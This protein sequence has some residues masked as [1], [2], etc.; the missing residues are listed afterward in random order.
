MFLPYGKQNLPFMKKTIIGALVGGIIIFFVQFLTWTVLGVHNKSQQYTPKQDSILAYLNTLGLKS[1][2]YLLPTA[3]PGSTSEQQ[4]NYFKD[5]EGKSWAVLDYHVSYHDTM[6]MSMIR[7]FV[8]NIVIVALLCWILL[9]IPAA[10]FGTIFLASLFTAAIVYLNS[11]YTYHIWYK[12][13]GQ[14][15]YIIDYAAQWGITGLWLGWW[16]RKK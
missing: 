11:N 14:K 13:P 2:Q 7:V 16:L 9:K 5:K 10:S 1:G 12:T 4:M 3:P 8:V 6:T 15:G